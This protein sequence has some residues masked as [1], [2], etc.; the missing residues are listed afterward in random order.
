MRENDA[1]FEWFE[2]DQRNQTIAGNGF[3][4]VDVGNGLEIQGRLVILS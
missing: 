2:A 1:F 3:F 4:F